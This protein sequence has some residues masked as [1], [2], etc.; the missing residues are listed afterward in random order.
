M[1]ENWRGDSALSIGLLSANLP[2][3]RQVGRSQR[4]TA[5]GSVGELLAMLQGRAGRGVGK[6]T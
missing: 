2:H 6:S 4:A 3:Y 5:R 1:V